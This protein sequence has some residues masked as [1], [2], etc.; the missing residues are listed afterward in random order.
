[1]AYPEILIEIRARARDEG[2]WNLFM[3]DE[4]YGAGLGELGVRGAL[5]GDGPQ[6]GWSPRW[7]ST[8]RRP[9]TGN[10]E[11][12]AE[13][14]SDEQRERWLEPL[15][16]GQIRSC[17]SMTEPDVAGS[18]P[19]TLQAPRRA[20]RRRVGGQ[21]AQVVHLG[22]R[23]RVAG[24][25]DGRH[26][27]RRPPYARASMILVPLDSAG[28]RPGSPG[29]GDGPRRGPRP[30]RDPLRPTAA[31]P[32]RAC[33]GSA[34][35]GFVIAQDRLGPGRIHHCMRAIGTAERAIE[36]M[37]EARQRPR[38][39]RREA[40]REAVRPGLH[41]PLADGG[42]SG[43]PADP[44]RRLEDGHGR[45]ARRPP[46]DLDDQ[47]RCRERRHGRA[48]PRDPGARRARASPTTRRSPGCG[49]TAACSG[50]PTAPT[51]STRW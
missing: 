11:I 17:F 39:V 22:R 5:R 20:R 48:R 18:D 25:R 42:R 50:S 26:R 28:L 21:R 49:A 37:C 33:S 27:P 46:G 3:P 44:V 4:R 29:P 10:M 30:L 6:P 32:P 24:D 36:L 7:P 34:A 13:H 47:G 8:A 2:L 31:S 45:K 41:R 14:G 16:D 35:P 38:G 1:M 12:L 23:R 51:R 15:L 9:D 40:G 43:A 19:T